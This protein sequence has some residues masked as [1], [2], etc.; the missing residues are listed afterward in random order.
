MAPALPAAPP[1]VPIRM[2]PAMQQLQA[3]AEFFHAMQGR[4]V[5]PLAAQPVIPPI[6]LA[7]VPEIQAGQGQGVHP[8]VAPLEV[9]EV[10]PVAAARDAPVLMAQPAIAQLV[11][12]RVA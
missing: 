11:I 3:M 10:V 12:D 9:D 5:L 6:A 1:I 4:F 2:M 8:V 7:P